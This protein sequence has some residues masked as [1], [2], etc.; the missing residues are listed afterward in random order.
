M[1]GVA[2]PAME[3]PLSEEGTQ[4]ETVDQQ[5][6]SAEL[7]EGGKKALDAERRR[8][9]TAEK[10]AK[11]LKARLDE[12]EASQLSEAEKVKLRADEAEARASAAE[13][14]ALRWRTAAKYGISDDDAALFLT[15]ADEDTLA[16]QAERFKEIAGKTP[17]GTVVPGVGNQ[18]TTPASISEQIA[19]AE[20]EGNYRMAIQLK[21]RQL[22]ELAKHNR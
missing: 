21:S 15:G 9:N 7:G 12:I 2:S 17:K 6:D 16:R 10:E 22:A 20:R 14:E 1:P 8:A 18:P 3:E 19:V 4:P 13:T 5:S 11:Q